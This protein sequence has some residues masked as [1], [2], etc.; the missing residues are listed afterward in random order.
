MPTDHALT[1]ALLPAQIEALFA[2]RCEYGFAEYMSSVVC[3]LE[4]RKYV[5]IRRKFQVCDGHFRWTSRGM[6]IKEGPCLSVSGARML[7]KPK[8]PK[9]SALVTRAKKRV[10]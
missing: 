7:R 1:T 9:K 6:V 5:I 10:R 8:N 3:G 4:R 2:Q